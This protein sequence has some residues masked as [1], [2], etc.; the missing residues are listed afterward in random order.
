MLKLMF[1][2][3]LENQGDHVHAFRGDFGWR[4]EARA[5]GSCGQTDA[6][7]H[8]HHERPHIH[9]VPERTAAGRG[10]AGQSHSNVHIYHY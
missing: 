8:D 10:Q 7:H 2:C 3:H 6:G 5:A 9:Q 1:G 4:A